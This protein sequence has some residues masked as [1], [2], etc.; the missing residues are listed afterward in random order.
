MLSPGLERLG[1]DVGCSAFLS[2]S[3]KNPGACFKVSGTKHP[4]RK[5]EPL[6]PF[7]P[8]TERREERGGG[9]RSR[10]PASPGPAGGRAA[11][12]PAPGP[13]RAAGSASP[14]RRRR[15]GA[16][17]AGGGHVRPPDA[18][19]APSPQAPPAPLRPRGSLGA[20][21]PLQCPGRRPQRS[22]LLLLTPGWLPGEKLQVY[23][24]LAWKPF[25]LCSISSS[26]LIICVS[27]L[28]SLQPVPSCKSLGACWQSQDTCAPRCTP[29]PRPSSLL[30]LPPHPSSLRDL[31]LQRTLDFS[32]S[33]FPSSLSAHP[34]AP[35][36][37]VFLQAHPPPLTVHRHT[38][39]SS[40]P[41][42]TGPLR[43]QL[44]REARAQ[45]AGRQLPAQPRGRAAPSSRPVW[46]QGF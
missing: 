14:P 29:S 12:L 7:Q 43:S 41:S 38:Q 18:G 28:W 9:R 1:G 34:P 19:P 13:Q 26:S 31:W 21:R 40:L 45:T 17:G 32:K 24:R 5:L 10:R 16:R 46:K 35:P 4:G 30:L 27:W 23:H 33:L 22:C 25:H 36:P 3:S 11:R 20:S 44:T 6:L 37:D 42:I 39:S 2:T 15:C 8:A